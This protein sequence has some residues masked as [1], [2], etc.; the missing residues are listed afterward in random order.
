LY[1]LRGLIVNAQ[2]D[3]TVGEGAP[4][5]E[6]E[7]HVIDALGVVSIIGLLGATPSL[8]KPVT[9]ADGKTEVGLPLAVHLL[10]Q[11]CQS[12]LEMGQQTLSDGF[13]VQSK[14]IFLP[15]VLWPKC[16]RHRDSWSGH[17]ICL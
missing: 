10:A 5:Q 12:K 7:R 14:E 17:G 1:R 11:L 13:C 6:L 9:H 15:L 2:V 8:D 4:H 16:R 3:E